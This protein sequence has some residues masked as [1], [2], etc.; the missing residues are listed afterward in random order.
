M[1]QPVIVEDQ[2]LVR[3]ITLERPDCKNALTP[4]LA[5]E[6]ARA[7]AEAQDAR[8]VAI[9]GRHGAFCSG[10]DLR[11][12]VEAGPELLTKADEH[13]ACFQD[14]VRAIAAVAPPVVAVIDGPAAG[15]GCDLA[16]A[17]DLRIASDRAF[18]QESF[19]RIGLVPD[20]GGTWMLPRSVGLAK[21]LE[22]GLLAEKLDAHT[23]KALGL[24]YKVVPAAS[25]MDE[26]RA[27][28]ERLAAGPPLALQA[29]KRLMRDGLARD[30]T[31]GLEAEG[32]AQL[33][34]LQSE[35]FLEGLQA[36]LQKRRGDFRGR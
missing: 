3:W 7:V 29:V 15:F 34:C 21:A 33:R 17:C 25:L 28:L 16:L 14:V 1:S 31:A 12:A 4:A 2:G 24:V 6:I 27:L 9:A 13:L 36:F 11:A 22:L 10:L 35:D 30:F 23:A 8:A 32:K 19:T 5:R 18:F 26:A 20:G